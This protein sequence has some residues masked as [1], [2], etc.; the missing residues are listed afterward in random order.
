M[1]LPGV[2]F[3]LGALRI[4]TVT[5]RTLRLWV[6][7]CS[8]A[9]SRSAWRI[10][11]FSLLRLG[12]EQEGKVTGCWLQITQDGLSDYGWGPAPTHSH[13]CVKGGLSVQ[14]D[15]PAEAG[16]ELVS[17]M[18]E[19]ISVPPLGGKGNQRGT[20][21]SLRS[22]NPRSSFSWFLRVLLRAQH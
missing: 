20:E 4:V 8:A 19:E 11:S 13:T 21:V 6:P 9:R 5:L 16:Q 17:H 15:I 7:L 12:L 10:N 14:G 2:S 18:D 22:W 1:E 3:D